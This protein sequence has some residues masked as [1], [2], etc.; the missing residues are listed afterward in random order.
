MIQSA[1]GSN[2]GVEVFEIY[3]YL[4]DCFTFRYDPCHRLTLI[5][6]AYTLWIFAFDVLRRDGLLCDNDLPLRVEV[7]CIGSRLP[8]QILG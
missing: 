2:F 3:F 5:G 4:L 6:S 7:R 8:V 1:S